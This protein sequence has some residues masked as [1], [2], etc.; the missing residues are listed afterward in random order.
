MSVWKGEVGG[1]T[2]SPSSRELCGVTGTQ[3]IITGKVSIVRGGG[4]RGG[5]VEN[6]VQGAPWAQEGTQ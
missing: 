4:G 2:P 3:A 5:G 1:G 6:Q